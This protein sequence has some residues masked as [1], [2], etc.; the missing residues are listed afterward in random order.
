MIEYTTYYITLRLRAFHEKQRDFVKKFF[1]PWHHALATQAMGKSLAALLVA[2][3]E[4]TKVHV[5]ILGYVIQ[6]GLNQ[7]SLSRF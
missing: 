6:K 2:E 7:T 1:W 5:K 3:R 4:K